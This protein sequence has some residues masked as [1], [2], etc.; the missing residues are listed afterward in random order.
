MPC[1]IQKLILRETVSAGPLRACEGLRHS[2]R[3]ASDDV[4]TK[5]SDISIESRADALAGRPPV[6]F[7]C[8]FMADGPCQCAV[9]HA[10]F[11]SRW[12]AAGAMTLAG[13]G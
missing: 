12:K 11:L 13:S 2:P 3:R 10:T 8:R 9:D 1:L 4:F 7:S 6:G 5:P